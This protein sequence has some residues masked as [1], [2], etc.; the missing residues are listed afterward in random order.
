MR[1]YIRSGLKLIKKWKW[2]PRDRRKKVSD[3]PLKY[4]ENESKNEK[5]VVN[6]EGSSSESEDKNHKL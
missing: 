4:N 2:L 6:P 1:N 5:D 3:I